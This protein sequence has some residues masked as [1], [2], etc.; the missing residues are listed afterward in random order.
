MSR[1][2]P[3]KSILR[4][5]GA[6]LFFPILILLIAGAGCRKLV[7]HFLL[8]GYEQTNLVSDVQGY[9][10]ARIDSDLVNPWGIAVATSGPIWIS[11]NGTGLSSIFNK[12]GA[13]L[14]PAVSIPTPDS[15]GGGAPTGIVFNSTADFTFWVAKKMVTSRFIFATEDGTIAAWGGGNF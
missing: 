10:A 13:K 8:D 2:L 1:A 7:Q 12:S 3:K 4:R 14:R 11:D 6:I 5:N 9:G 15:S